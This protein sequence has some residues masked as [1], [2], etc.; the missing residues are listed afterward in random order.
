MPA[1]TSRY[2]YGLMVVDPKGDEV[3]LLLQR[4]LV[5][6]ALHDS[7]IPLA[8]EEVQNRIADMMGLESYPYDAAYYG[9]SAGLKNK[10]ILDASGSQFTLTTLGQQGIETLRNGVQT[11][12]MAFDAYFSALLPKYVTG[13]QA[14]SIIGAL[15]RDLQVVLSQK[16][17]HLSKSLNENLKD[18]GALVVLESESF[19]NLDSTLTE[20]FPNSL[21]A[22][23]VEDC[24]YQG[25]ADQKPDAVALY[26]TS[27]YNRSF[28]HKMLLLDPEFQKLQ[29]TILRDWHLYLDTNVLIALLVRTHRE[30]KS[31]R[32]VI[33]RCANIGCNL[34]VTGATKKE[35]ETQMA[36]ARQRFFKFLDGDPVARAAVN[37]RREAFVHDFFES[38]AAKTY[39]TIDLYLAMYQPVQARLENEMIELQ[40][41]ACDSIDTDSTMYRDIWNELLRVKQGLG[42]STRQE[43]ITHDALNLA[44]IHQ[45]RGDEREEQPNAVWFL[46]FDR[47]PR[48]AELGLRY[49]PATLQVG[50]LLSIMAVLGLPDMTALGP[51]EY[52]DLLLSSALAALLPDISGPVDDF[53]Q[54]IE[55]FDLPD[56]PVE[57]LDSVLRKL[58]YDREVRTLLT[59]YQSTEDAAEKAEMSKRVYAIA[60]QYSQSAAER[61]RNAERVQHLSEALGTRDTRIADLEVKLES[62]E[63]QLQEVGQ[64]E[65]QVKTQGPPPWKLWLIASAAFLAGIFAMWLMLGR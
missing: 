63:R 62:I 14:T 53:L 55:G 40:P 5:E 57:S 58:S 61:G 20:V 16:A 1:A 56:L 19:N 17:D 23:E 18:L 7:P 6:L 11:S 45:L 24:I 10:T 27:L 60:E 15:K 47:S 33:Q 29:R 9:I 22:K 44:L 65:G 30:H 34:Y 3:R 50:E 64:K 54:D 35:L 51:S 4:Q 49:R 52:A 37:S 2:L 46:S 41:N 12:E 36:V 8:V 48:R 43:T 59:K 21:N 38:G 31:I 28:Y 13:K 26:I 32:E 25:L 42:M 39:K